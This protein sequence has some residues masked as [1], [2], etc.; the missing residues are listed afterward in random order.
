MDTLIRSKQMQKQDVD[1]PGIC[2]QEKCAN[3][4]LLI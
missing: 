1:K 2:G 4:F 3:V